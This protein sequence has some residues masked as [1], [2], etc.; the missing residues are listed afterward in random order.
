MPKF[1]Q[2]TKTSGHKQE[3]IRDAL[4]IWPPKDLY[5]WNN[6]AKTE[7]CD[8]KPTEGN[9]NATGNSRLL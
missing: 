4:K 3:Y 6:T 1:K 5:C 2:F 7:C 9:R 8:A